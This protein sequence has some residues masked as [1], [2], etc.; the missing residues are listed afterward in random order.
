M[1][2]LDMQSCN[3]L[4]RA[5]LEHNKSGEGILPEGGQFATAGAFVGILG[6]FK[7]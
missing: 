1:D 2:L 7:Y 6:Y 5:I 3:N 4:P